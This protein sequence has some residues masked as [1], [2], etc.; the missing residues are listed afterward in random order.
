M[1]HMI[2]HEY[3]EMSQLDEP[4]F[5]ALS[6]FYSQTNNP[7]RLVVRTIDEL[8]APLPKSKVYFTPENTCAIMQWFNSI[9]QWNGAKTDY[10]F[11][12]GQDEHGSFFQ[13]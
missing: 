6:D 7:D 11:K 3:R 8:K 13:Y 9:R 12:I 4:E 2:K 10:V 1:K 5:I